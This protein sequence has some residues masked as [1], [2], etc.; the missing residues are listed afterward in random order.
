M[1]ILTEAQAIDLVAGIDPEPTAAPE[2]VAKPSQEE[3]QQ[4][5]AEPAEGLL[6]AAEQ[7]EDDTSDSEPVEDDEP[8]DTADAAGPIS[9][10]DLLES[11]PDLV[12]A[13]P[14]DGGEVTLQ[15]LVDGNLR[16]A[17]YTQKTQALAAERK[18]FEAQAQSIRS[19][20]E[21]LQTLHAE[22][23]NLLGY[24]KQQMMSSFGNVEALRENDPA[25]YAAKIADMHQMNAMFSA[26]ESKRAERLQQTMQGMQALKSQ[27]LAQ[28]AEK[29]TTVIPEWK[30]ESKA[31]AERTAIKQMADAEGINLAEPLVEQAAGVKL[32]RELVQYRAVKGGEKRTKAPR[33]IRTAK[34]SVADPK[35]A[36]QAKADKTLANLRKMN[37][38]DREAAAVD[39]LVQ[40]QATRQ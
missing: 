17:S 31:E 36:A 21:Q 15:E 2:A 37:Q 23:E 32:L 8:E 7:T 6:E 16:N 38:S 5:E 35:K 26:L 33:L 19:Q 29:L 1:G 24:F 20:A 40:R 18:E 27:T 13:L 34:R 12:V 4:P 11:N 22:N 39:L 25:E 30:D 9:V 10:A 3:E 14:G 28:E